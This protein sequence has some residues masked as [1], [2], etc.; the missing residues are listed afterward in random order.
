MYLPNLP[1][2][3]VPILRQEADTPA[4][5]V[6]FIGSSRPSYHLSNNNNSI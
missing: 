6:G 5:T 4:E 2:A 3:V 1:L